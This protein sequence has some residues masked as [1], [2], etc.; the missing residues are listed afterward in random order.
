LQKVA[1]LYHFKTK[2]AINQAVVQLL[3]ENGTA[4]I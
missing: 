2:E 3:S 1:L 4:Y